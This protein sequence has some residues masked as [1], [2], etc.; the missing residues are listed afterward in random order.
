MYT[1]TGKFDKAIAAFDRA[2]ALSD[3]NMA[4]IAAG[5]AVAY[6][7]WGKREEAKDILARLKALAEQKYV[8]PFSLAII[9][10]ALG[11]K[12]AAFSWLEKAYQEKSNYLVFLKVDPRLNP[13]RHDR[14]FEALQRKIGL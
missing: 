14:R 2:L 12:D 1:L 4:Y 10:A 8:S 6:A 3:S 9:H 11:D 5:K 13:L 7:H